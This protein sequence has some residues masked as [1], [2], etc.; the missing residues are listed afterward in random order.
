VNI[1]LHIERLVI[2]GLPRHVAIFGGLGWDPEDR[3]Y[4]PGITFLSLDERVPEERRFATPPNARRPQRG[5]LHETTAVLLATGEILIMG[6]GKD[7]DQDHAD[8]QQHHQDQD[9]R[10]QYVKDIDQNHS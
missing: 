3:G 6:G 5:M 1:Q 2:E 9:Q 10:N 4:M 8:R 7:A